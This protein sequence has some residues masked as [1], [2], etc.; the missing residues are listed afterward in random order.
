MSKKPKVKA[1]NQRDLVGVFERL[2]KHF[3]KTR[4][5]PADSRFEVMVGAILGQNT[6]WTNVEKALN[7]LRSADALTPTAILDLNH[8]SLAELLRPSGYYNIKAK[9]LRNFVEWFYGQ[10][11]CKQLDSRDT[12]SLRLDLL[13]IN[14]IGNETADDMLLYAFERPVFIVDAYTRRLFSRLGMID[15]EEKYDEL[16]GALGQALTG[17]AALYNEYHALIV[18]LAKDYCRVKPLCMSCPLGKHC[19]FEP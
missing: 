13:A 5:W 15:G 6:A 16:S 18:N 10:G 8:E 19:Q 1:L 3:G 17:D 7:N 2:S 12:E 4:W 14:G 9:R 11:E